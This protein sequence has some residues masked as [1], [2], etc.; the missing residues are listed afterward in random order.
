V[1]TNPGNPTGHRLSSAARH[2][3][4]KAAGEAGAWLLADEVYQ[5]AERDG[6]TTSSFWGSYDRLLV[7]NGMSKAYG[8][9]G[10][11]IGWMVASREVIQNAWARQDYTVIGPSPAS[12][13]LARCAIQARPKILERT[14]GILKANY[15]ILEG[16]LG[17]FKD[18][19]DWKPPEAGAIC[20]VRFRHQL[21]TLELVERIRADRSVLLVPGE[22]FGM[23]PGFLRIGFGNEAPEL[24]AALEETRKGLEKALR[25]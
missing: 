12:D 14:R 3:I 20:T 15:P 10:L 9:P 1:V 5:G 19:F 7:V 18:L 25:D 6:H 8:L 21:E 22:H 2:A 23:P 16:W 13:Y 11:R 24:Q 17:G 4:I